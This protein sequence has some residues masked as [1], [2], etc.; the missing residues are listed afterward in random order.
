MVVETMDCTT[1]KEP[2]YSAKKH[3]SLV[4]RGWR[5]LS[6]KILNIFDGRRDKKVCGFSLTRYV[7][8][9]YRQAMGATG[10]QATRYWFLERVFQGAHFSPDDQVIDVGC[11]K[12]RVFAYLTEQ[13]VTCAMHGVE[14]NEDVVDTARKWTEKYPN[15]SITC[16]DAFQIDYNRYSVLLLGRPFEL[17]TLG[18]FIKK[19]E[20]ELTRPVTIFIWC[21]QE[22]K[23]VLD[24]RFGWKLHRRG[25]MFCRRG[26]LVCVAPQRF[27]VWTYD[28]TFK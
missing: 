4:M 28:P 13:G 2:A 7:P 17:P 12:A 15:I 25:W 9:K 27:S 24:G 22:T 19:L 26:L 20:Q 3:Y 5:V 14:L 10:S 18:K 16:E 23:D 1:V 8:S 6:R 11:G 21:D